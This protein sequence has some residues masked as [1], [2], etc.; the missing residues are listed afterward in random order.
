MNCDIE[1]GALYTYGL[2]GTVSSFSA[3]DGRVRMRV[4]ISE[5]FIANNSFESAYVMRAL[6]TKHELSHTYI[7]DD[8]C[9]VWTNK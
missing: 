7:G 6:K 1:P 3:Y 9:I 2:K 8:A 5:G 4:V